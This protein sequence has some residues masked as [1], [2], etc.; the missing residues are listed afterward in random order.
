MYHIYKHSLAL[1]KYIQEEDKPVM[2]H[3]ILS[4]LF[5]NGFASTAF[6]RNF[7]IFQC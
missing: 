6:E 5:S 1:D 7:Y 4:D 2:F 3:N